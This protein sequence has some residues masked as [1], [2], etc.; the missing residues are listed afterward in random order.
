M[1]NSLTPST[2]RRERSKVKGHLRRLGTWTHKPRGQ[3]YRV[4]MKN[5][6]YRKSLYLYEVFSFPCV[7]L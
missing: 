5:N 7:V 4:G 3:L 2:M 1:P 6:L